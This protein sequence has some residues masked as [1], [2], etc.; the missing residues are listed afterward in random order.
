MIEGKLKE[1]FGPDVYRA[2]VSER[3]HEAELRD[4]GAWEELSG[5][6]TA[7]MRSMR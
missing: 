6:M 5:M 3:I 4:E 1:G 2:F 7:L